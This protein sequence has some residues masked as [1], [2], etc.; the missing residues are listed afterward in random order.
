MQLWKL[1]CRWGSKT[2]VFYDYIVSNNIVIASIDKDYQVGDWLLITDGHLVLSFAKIINARTSVL[3][4]PIFAKDFAF[5]KIPF[6]N[7]MFFYEAEFI[8]LKTE[9]RFNYPLQQGIV[10][11]QGQVYIDTFYK[12]KNK[13]LNEFKM[14]QIINLLEYKKQIILQGPPGTGKTRKAKEIAIELLGL[15]NSI[16]Q[17]TPSSNDLQSIFS[18]AIDKKIKTV[19]ENVEY[20]ILSVENEKVKLERQNGSTD[21]T[22]FTKILEFYSNR[23]WEQS[24]TSNDDRRAAALAKFFYSNYSNESE[25]LN[26]QFKLIQFHPSYSYEDFVR[27]IVAKPNEG[28]DGVLYEAENKLLGLFATEALDNYRKSKL[29]TAELSIEKWVEEKWSD[30]VLKIE[31]ETAKNGMYKLTDKVSIREVEDDCFKYKGDDWKYTSRINFKDCKQLLKHFIHKKSTKVEF[32]K[33]ISRHAYYRQSYYAPILEN[34][35]SIEE[36]KYTGGSSVREE[37]KNYILVIDEINRA[38][39]SSVLGELIYA[40][41]YR[42]KEVESMYAIDGE[43]KLILPPNLYIIGTMNTADRSVGNIDYAIRRRFAFVDVLPEDLSTTLKDKFNKV[44]F[45]KVT[46]LF[47]H[48]T[49]L[50]KEFEAKDVQLGHSYFIDKTEEGATM[51]MR[52]DY[53]IKPILREYIKD[54]V[55]IGEKIKDEIEA[56]TV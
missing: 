10:K 47:N 40:L 28:G 15:N 14:Q 43:N 54:G 33:S 45:D 55:L 9:D 20:K 53:E 37:L 21:D 3:E 29:D 27:G 8:H 46:T 11:V 5:Y 4:K 17:S 34:Y 50:S 19:A 41:E 52:L 44:L 26:S 38:N 16:Q 35:N 42:G 30:Y 31:E 23:K 36:N 18:K 51:Q 6:N 22:S 1:G 25:I 2:P 24:F 13:Y 56:L 48:N 49:C 32:D 7:T 39:L 12:L